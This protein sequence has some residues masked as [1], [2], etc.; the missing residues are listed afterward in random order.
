MVEKVTLKAVTSILISQPPPENGK[1]PYLD[2]GVENGIKVTN[3]ILEINPDSVDAICIMSNLLVNC[4]KISEAISILSNREL[5]TFEI[6]HAY[7][8][9]LGKS[10][11]VDKANEILFKALEYENSH[12]ILD[13]IAI[14][15]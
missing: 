11:L 9:A 10:R 2:F 5:N 4:G 8:F 6:C 12:I 14:N 3:K 7:G 13:L 1:S 15:L